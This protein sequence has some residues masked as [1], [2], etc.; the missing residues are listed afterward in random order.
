[1][2]SRRAERMRALVPKLRYPPR[3]AP[4]SRA[5]EKA[6]NEER[7]Q[8]HSKQHN[9]QIHANAKTKMV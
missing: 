5:D 6:H 4:S 9:S 2:G 1:M 8:T 7:R 3:T